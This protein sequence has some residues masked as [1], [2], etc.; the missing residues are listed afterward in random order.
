MQQLKLE[1]P[2]AIRT[3]FFDA[4]FT[5]LRPSPSLIEVCQIVCRQYGLHLDSEQLSAQLPAAEA[6]FRE[7]GTLEQ[8]TWANEEA[9]ARFWIGYYTALLRPFITEENE[10]LLGQCVRTILYEFRQHTRWELFPDVLPTLEALQ[11]KGFTL[12]IISDWE[13][14]LGSI[15]AGLDLGRY[16]DCLVISAV[17]RYAKPE[18]QLYETALQRANA[19][20]D[21]AIHIGD[22]YIH[23]VLGARSVGITAILLDRPGLLRAEDVDCHLIRDLREVLK[24]LEIHTV[25]TLPRPTQTRE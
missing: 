9:I 17:T 19:I 4:G 1:A 15:V 13:T 21:Y 2:Q 7:A 18:Y 5:L 25:A 20:P 22:S 16:F 8:R 11:G 14:S 6:Y 10:T 24:L 12:G 23:D 3:I